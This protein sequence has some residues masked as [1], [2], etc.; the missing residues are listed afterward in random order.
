MSGPSSLRRPSHFAAALRLGSLLGIVSAGS[1]L[2][3]A[4]ARPAP[5][6]ALGAA[7]SPARPAPPARE[8]V[9]GL[10]KS[11]TEDE[12]L[13]LLGGLAFSTRPVAR[14]GIP[15]FQM[16]D[17][18]LGLRIPGP[19]NAYAAGMALAASWD[20]ALAERVGVQLGRDARSRCVQILLGP[21]VNLYRAPMNG[22]NFEYFGEDPWLASRIAVGYVRGVQSQGVSATIKHFVGNDSEYARRTSD[23][24]IDER[25]LRELYLPAFEAAVKE[26]R[27]GAVMSGY[28]LTNGQHM[29]A[30]PRLV[31]EILK[32]EWGFDGIF[33]SDWEATDDG[34][35]A[36]NAGLDL[37]MPSGKFMNRETLAPALRDGRLTR[38]VVDDKLRRLLGL[39]AR[40]GWLDGQKC[41]ATIPRYNQPGREVARQGALEG[42]VLLKNAGN[43]LPL[44]PG[45][46]RNVA[47][48]GPLAHP[49]EP[50][51][52]GSGKV[53]TFQTVSLLRGLSESLG[54][55]VNVTHAV[56]VP[57]L[58]ALAMRTAF[59]TQRGGGEPGLVVEEFADE[60]FQGPPLATRTEWTLSRSSTF[61]GD[62]D[63]TI[64][65]DYLSPERL[66][67]QRELRARSNRDRHHERWTGW[68][69]PERA[70]PHTLFLVDTGSYRLRLDG[71]LVLENT[72]PQKAALRQLHVS[73]GVGPHQLV[74]EQW[75]GREG[76]LPAFRGGIVRDEDIVDPL[77][78]RLA[79]QADVAVVAVGFDPEIETEGA[80]REFALPPG[81]DQLVREIAAV[82]PRTIVVL[83]SGGAVDVSAWLDRVPALL[84]AW[85]P[86]QEGGAALS[87]LLLGRASPSGRVPFSWERRLEDNPSSGNYYYNDPAHPNRILYR[88][89]LFVGYR[90]YQQRGTRPLFPFGFGLSYTSF[91]YANLHIAAAPAAAAG[92]GARAP[93]YLASFDLTNTGARAG[94]DV[95]QLYVSPAPSQVPRPKRELKAFERVELAPGET[96]HVTLPLDARSFAHYDVQGQ[97]WQAEAG[98]Y[99]VELA[100]S[101]EDVQQ[102]AE[103]VLPAPLV[104]PA[105]D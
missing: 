52:G 70:G 65:R 76:R 68:Y 101:V 64:A 46:L 88:E 36:A 91:R 82:N 104:I 95:A 26:A 93:L 77:A 99:G 86:G 1:S 87:E 5:T 39:A 102:R 97:H 75:P 8:R 13:D 23:S 44:D 25:S 3:A 29:T 21:G 22:R 96:R 89:G 56:G 100:R 16:S 62:A 38:A 78:K 7:S 94:A 79:A 10:L 12:A 24:N 4:P 32:R 58:R 103:V 35:A 49:G 34:L 105:S 42:T 73:L 45:R 59:F 33:M 43:L 69:S 41:D 71:K 67:L 14:L 92:P 72:N 37:E 51:G 2:L 47:L 9:E 80:D 18:P 57:P 48:I 19:S 98:R 83:T 63:L 17:G 90:G 85:Y 54:V 74:L 66:Q 15:S 30:N 28:N 60:K 27:V 50:T 20:P 81:Q 53:V 11:L 31:N 84:A 6:P 55:S 61:S 40:F